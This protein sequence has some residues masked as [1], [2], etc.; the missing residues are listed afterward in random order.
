M[1][2]NWDELCFLGQQLIFEPA[3]FMIGSHRSQK[4]N[5]WMP[6]ANFSYYIKIRGRL[7]FCLHLSLISETLILQLV[8][9]GWGTIGSKSQKFTILASILCSSRKGFLLMWSNLGKIKCATDSIIS[10]MRIL[11]A[12][13]WRGRADCEERKHPFYGLKRAAVIHTHNLFTELTH[14]LASHSILK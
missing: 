10:L 4:R 5:R 1:R 7:C 3:V 9:R 14:L 11:W 8:A 2:L 6:L 13:K 12:V